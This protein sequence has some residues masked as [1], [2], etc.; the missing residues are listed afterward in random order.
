MPPFLGGNMK[1]YLNTFIVAGC[2]GLLAQCI[3]ALYTAMG[4]GMPLLMVAVMMTLAAFGL[5]FYATG[6]IGKL[7]RISFVAMLFPFMGLAATVAEG[8]GGRKQRGEPSGKAFFGAVGEILGVL[9]PGF[10]T[11]VILALVRTFVL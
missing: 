8:A 3:A 4:I 11:A 2:M 10:A 9:L 6:I 1:R 5:I 7:N